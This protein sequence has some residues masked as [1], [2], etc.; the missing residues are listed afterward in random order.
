MEVRMRWARVW[1]VVLAVGSGALGGCDDSGPPMNPFPDSGTVDA[2]TVDA[3][4]S[5][6]GGSQG[7]DGGTQVDVDAGTDA[8]S[9]GEPLP[10]EKTQGVC[11]G[12]RRAVVDGAYE[13]V[14]T[15]LSYGSAYEATESRCDGLD[16]DCDGVTDPPTWSQATSLAL[17]A[18]GGRISTLRVTDGV[19]AVVVDRA[20]AARVIRL[21]TEMKPLEVTEVPL[22]IDGTA[23]SLDS[24]SARLLRTAQGPALYYASA[25]PSADRLRGYLIRLDEQGH[26]VRRDGEP[27]GGTLLFDEPRWDMSSVATVSADGTRVLT[28]W[29]DNVVSLGGRDLWGTLVELS[30]QVVVSP[31]ILMRAL[32]DDTTLRNLGVMGLRDGGFLALVQ[33]IKE[34]A[35][36]GLLRLQ[37]FDAALKPVGDERTFSAE[38]DPETRLVDLGAAA[39]GALESPVIVLRSVAGGERALKVL[40]NLFGEATTHTLA[41]TTSDEVPW[42]GT[43]VTARGLEAAWLS[44]SGGPQGGNSAFGWQG[45]FWALG[46]GGIAKDLSPG[47]DFMPLHRFAQWVQLEELPEHW[48]GALV[49]T[50]TQSPESHTLQAVRYCAP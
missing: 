25:G 28:A 48:M 19:L 8:G 29:R 16:N 39:G 22:A 6:A 31:R 18:H 26:R 9:L 38:A 49:M 10:C 12:A 37:H 46:Q 33:E 27:A 45:R 21:D 11:A 24:V 36:E 13:S 41:V 35:P 50:S 7:D 32:A 3:G 40:G 2:G 5:D 34:G 20:S 15:A 44:V 4:T 43:A 17:P 42:Y 30:G 14:C 47:P 1:A 23:V